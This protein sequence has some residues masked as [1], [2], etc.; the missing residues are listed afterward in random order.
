MIRHTSQA[1]THGSSIRSRRSAPQG[2]IRMVSILA[3]GAGVG[4]VACGAGDEP[5]DGPP[6]FSSSGLNPSPS[7]GSTG[8][9]QNPGVTNNGTTGASNGSQNQSGST[10]AANGSITPPPANTPQEGNPNAAPIDNA[11]DQNAGGGMLSGAGGAG[12]TNP[13]AMG[14][15]GN[16]TPP[17]GPADADGTGGNATPPVDPGAADGSGDPA[18]P[19]DPGGAGGDPAPPV[20]QLPPATPDIPCPAGATFCSGFESDLLPE[21]VIYQS[22]PAV[23]LEFDTT[24]RRGGARSLRVVSAGGFNIRQVVVPIPG[25]SFWVRLFVQTSDVF[26]DNN[27]DSLFVASTAST[28]QDN[29]AENGPEFSEQGNQIVLNA[30]DSLFSAA[31]PGFPQGTGPQLSPNTWHCEE[32]FYDGATGDTQIFSDG[33]QLIDA[34]GFTPLTYQTFRFGYIGFNTVRTV[35]F[36]DVVVAPDRIGCD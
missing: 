28:S 21:G 27:H 3:L 34:A 13:G 25:Q 35:W 8:S 19:A 14:G 5:A 2:G 11:N 26:G 6:V 4:L 22:Q 17:V 36:D 23:D 31:G 15:A 20:Q 24:V 9:A 18:P 30:N 32:A 33:V 29:N 12:S 10:P 1:M 7:N 16:A